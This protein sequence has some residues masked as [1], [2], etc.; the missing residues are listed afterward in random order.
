M[1]KS[2]LYESRIVKA[3]IP[4]EN[5]DDLRKRVSTEVT[6][7]INSGGQIQRC[8]PC[9]YGEVT[10]VTSAQKEKMNRLFG[11]TRNRWDK[12]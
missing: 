4:K 3:D 9:T 11:T 2:W 12:T 6:A 10:A 1:D 5:K 7:Y 8:P